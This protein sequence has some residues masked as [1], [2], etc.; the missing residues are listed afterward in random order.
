LEKAEWVAPFEDLKMATERAEAGK[1]EDDYV[2]PLSRQ[3]VALLRGLHK[4]SELEELMPFWADRLDQ[5]RRRPDGGANVIDL[6]N[7]A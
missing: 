3:A 5:M 1:S 2:I 6:S 4:V 7:L